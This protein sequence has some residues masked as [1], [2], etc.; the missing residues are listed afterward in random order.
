LAADHAAS[1]TGAISEQTKGAHMA[2]VNATVG[3]YIA[4]WNKS[5]PARRRRLIEE[6]WTEDARYLDPQISGEGPEGID[7]MIAAA[8][9]PFP[10]YSFKL[11]G[12]PDTHNDPSLHLAPGRWGR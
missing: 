9:E 10:G 4:S 7:A 12:E 3:N 5:D 8:Q 11:A 6:T 1:R 2:D